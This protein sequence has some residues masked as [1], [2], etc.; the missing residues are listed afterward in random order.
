MRHRI[1]IMT[2]LLA[3]TLSAMAQG[4]RKITGTVTDEM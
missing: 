3:M 2:M 4:T 1:W